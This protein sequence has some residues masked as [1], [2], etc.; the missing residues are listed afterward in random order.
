MKLYIW[1]E[2]WAI[3]INLSYTLIFVRVNEFL[4][5]MAFLGWRNK[6]LYDREKNKMLQ[7]ASGRR[8]RRE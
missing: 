2:T 5:S 4:L 7:V 8:S 3:A 1:T 6:A